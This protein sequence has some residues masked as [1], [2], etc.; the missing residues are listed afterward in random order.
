MV[1][2]T[3]RNRAKIKKAEK[4]PKKPRRALK[5]AAPRERKGAKK[6]TVKNSRP[7]KGKNNAG[8]KRLF[9]LHPQKFKDLIEIVRE[10]HFKVTACNAVGISE[11]TLY[12]ELQRNPEFAESL[13]QAEA[14]SEREL[15]S[16]I[17]DAA[18]GRG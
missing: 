13:R 3:K 17:Q 8:R 2:T 1:R 4:K 14:E 7:K 16:T 6:K 12:E 5:A 10:G 15:I 11:T 9:E 18:F